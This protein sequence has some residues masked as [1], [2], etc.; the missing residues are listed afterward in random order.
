MMNLDLFHELTSCTFCH[1]MLVAV[2]C[3]SDDVATK[4]LNK[5]LQ[6]QMKLI[7]PSSELDAPTI[8]CECRCVTKEH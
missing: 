2:S 7:Q 1:E 6:N 8:V 4:T 5:P 3:V